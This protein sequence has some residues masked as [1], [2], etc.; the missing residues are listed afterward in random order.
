MGISEGDEEEGEEGYEEEEEDKED[1]EE[2]EEEEEVLVG[3]KEQ[4]VPKRKRSSTQRLTYTP[5]A[6][7]ADKKRPRS[8]KKSKAA[9]KRSSFSSEESSNT[10]DVEE[11]KESK[12][13]NSDWIV[14]FPMAAISNAQNM[15]VD[16]VN[17]WRQ[18]D[19]VKTK[20]EDSPGCVFE[21]LDEND[22]SYDTAR[23]KLKR[24]VLV[25]ETVAAQD[26]CT[27]AFLCQSSQQMWR[28]GAALL[29]SGYTPQSPLVCTKGTKGRKG[30]K[31]KKGKEDLETVFIVAA[32]KSSKKKQ[33]ADGPEELWKD[34]FPHCTKEVFMYN[35][36][37]NHRSLEEQATIWF[38]ASYV[39]SK[40][41]IWQFSSSN[42]PFFSQAAIAMGLT[43]RA[44][45]DSA[46]EEEDAA[47]G[48]WSKIE[49][50]R[51][52]SAQTECFTNYD[53][54]QRALTIISLCDETLGGIDE[55]CSASKEVVLAKPQGSTVTQNCSQPDGET[56]NFQKV[57]PR[58]TGYWLQ[59]STKVDHTATTGEACT[60]SVAKRNF[61]A[62]EHFD[63][64]L[65]HWIPAG[66]PSPA[67][68]QL[69]G[70]RGNMPTR[71]EVTNKLHFVS[72]AP[73]DFDFMKKTGVLSDANVCMYTCVDE[74]HGHLVFRTQF[75][76]DVDA[77]E[78]LVW[79]VKKVHPLTGVVSVSLSNDEDLKTR[80]EFLLETK[81]RLKYG[82]TIEAN[83]IAFMKKLGVNGCLETNL[84]TEQGGVT[85]LALHL[86]TIYNTIRIADYDGNASETS[87][88]MS[89]LRYFEQT[90]EDE[91]E[92]G[93]LPDEQLAIM[94]KED[95]KKSCKAV[96]AS[97]SEWGNSIE[98]LKGKYVLVKDGAYGP[99]ALLSDEPPQWLHLDSVVPF[100]SGMDLDSR[101]S[102][103]C[104]LYNYNVLVLRK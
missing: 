31:G 13:T 98:E 75:I 44:L 6:S 46:S 3:M 74:P 64:F 11:E 27:L 23:E 37:M 54:V 18:Q 10:S 16:K 82:K 79:F 65:G 42:Y 53:M 88:R 63:N 15:D 70:W 78:E 2:E 47:K 4:R 50:A 99:H 8:T 26:S 33:S 73:Q 39:G 62:G 76:K 55:H 81:F 92:E 94:K 95:W 40:T 102:H 7:V 25:L 17:A 103:N 14:P 9:G 56:E 34:I 66:V 87:I 19:D 84:C 101:F 59:G 67:E 48:M 58:S 45:Y 51:A 12:V 36:M 43:V 86:N 93:P 89:R 24:R 57:G 35:E 41:V 5:Q 80:Q 60:R 38:L 97:V 72:S 100:L 22:K 91:K 52:Y 28:I 29:E 1:E 96:Y 69:S 20:V 49:L 71:L 30:K 85:D 104:L 21:L 90:A 32:R 61:K 83:H 68:K 77:N